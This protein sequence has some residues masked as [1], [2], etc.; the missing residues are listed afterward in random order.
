MGVVALTVVIGLVLFGL[1]KFKQIN[2]FG[3]LVA[4]VFGVLLAATPSG[5]RLT[6]QIRVLADSV[7][8][9][10]GSL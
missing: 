5:P 3:A 9:W 1:L 2:A 10:L 6:D 8:S 4:V 7:D